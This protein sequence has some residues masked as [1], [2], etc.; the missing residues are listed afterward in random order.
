[1]RSEYC[2]SQAPIPGWHWP[3][4]PEDVFPLLSIEPYENVDFFV[5]AQVND[6]TNG[7]QSL[8]ERVNRGLC[9]GRVTIRANHLRDERCHGGSR[10]GPVDSIR[11]PWTHDHIPEQDQR[12]ERPQQR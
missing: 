9:L 10:Q 6:G 3:E 8:T 11:R 5:I 4:L 7:P 12:P 1:M 2:R